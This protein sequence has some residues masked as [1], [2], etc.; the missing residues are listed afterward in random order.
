MSEVFPKV[1]DSKSTKASNN[2]PFDSKTKFKSY[3]LMYLE[4]YKEDKLNDWINHIKSHDM[5]SAKYFS[6]FK[7]GFKSKKLIVKLKKS[8]F[9]I[10]SVPGRFPATKKI[11][12]H[13]R[14]R[15]VIYFIWMKFNW[16]FNNYSN[17]SWMIFLKLALNLI[18]MSVNFQVL[19][20]WVPLKING[21]A[22]NLQNHFQARI[23]QAYRNY[24]DLYWFTLFSF[25][26]FYCWKNTPQLIQIYPCINDVGRSYES[27]YAGTS[28]PYSK[29]VAAKQPYLDN[30]F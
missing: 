18:N 21:Y 16:D 11:F 10:G 6:L 8:V 15:K 20:R 5:S 19:G 1:P 3:L 2:D 24:Q 29:A 28:L 17:R 13:L 9:L 30:F 27:F 26:F 12:G 14:L 25:F 4:Y 22:R 23:F 7:Y